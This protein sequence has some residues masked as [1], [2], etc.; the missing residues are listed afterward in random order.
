VVGSRVYMS[1]T[2][3]VGTITS[4]APRTSVVQLFS[5]GGLK[6]QATLARTGATYELVGSGGANF[7]LEVPKETDVALGDTFLYPNSSISV[8]AIV[9]DIDNG[10]QS[11]FKKVYLR[12]PGNIFSSQWLFVDK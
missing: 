12:I 2:I 4:V 6:Q 7:Q 8:L 3:V 11:S 9:Y 1:D 10:S 5:T